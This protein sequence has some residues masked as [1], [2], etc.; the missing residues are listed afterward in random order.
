MRHRDYPK[1]RPAR[2]VRRRHPVR[3][4]ACEKG[5]ALRQPLTST[6]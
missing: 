1:T 4:L 3:H 6:S 5:I 2:L